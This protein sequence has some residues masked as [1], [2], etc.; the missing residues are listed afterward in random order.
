MASSAS[1]RYTNMAALSHQHLLFKQ[2]V[3]QRL[4][5]MSTTKAHRIYSSINLLI[6]RSGKSK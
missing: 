4:P 3:E 2:D 6:V 1:A 5:G